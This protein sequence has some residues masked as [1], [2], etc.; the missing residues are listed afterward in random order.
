MS[1]DVTASRRAHERLAILSEASTR[2]GTSLDVMQTSQ[3]LADLAVPLLADYAVVDLASRS[4][5]AKYPRPASARLD[6]RRPRPPA[7]GPGLDPPR[8]PGVPVG[9]R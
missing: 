5:S 2:I 4:R 7:R 3:E 8:N 6:D 9:A 1:V